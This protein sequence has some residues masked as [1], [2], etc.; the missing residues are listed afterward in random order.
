MIIEVLS[1]M[2]CGSLTSLPTIYQL[3]RGGQLY[4]RGNRACDKNNR[5][6]GFLTQLKG[7]DRVFS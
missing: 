6:N 7:P 5:K 3:Y 1:V 4:C 2:S